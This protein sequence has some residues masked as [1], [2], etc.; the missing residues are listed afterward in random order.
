[1]E[2]WYQG[3]QV[4]APGASVLAGL[5]AHKSGAR[6]VHGLVVA[7]WLAWERVAG[8]WFDRYGYNVWEQVESPLAAARYAGK[9]VTKELGR[10]WIGLHGGRFA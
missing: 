1:V 4:A 9:Y 3:V 7:D 5:E 6:H 10:F 8:W 2:G